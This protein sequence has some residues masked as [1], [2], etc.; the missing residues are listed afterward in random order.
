MLNPEFL[1]SPSDIVRKIHSEFDVYLKK[2]GSSSKKGASPK[3]PKTP[4]IDSAEN[5]TL[6]G[7]F[8]HGILDRTMNV[9]TT[10]DLGSIP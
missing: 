10:T 5:A 2:P 6:T 1:L 8:A 9:Y 7:T 4:N 3:K